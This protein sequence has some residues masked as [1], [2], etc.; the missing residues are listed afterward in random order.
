MFFTLICREH[1]VLRFSSE[2]QKWATGSYTY[3]WL[4]QPVTIY[5]TLCTSFLRY[6]VAFWIG[7]ISS[8]KQG[9]EVHGGAGHRTG[10]LHAKAVLQIAE[11]LVHLFPV[12]RGQ[13]AP[14]LSKVSSMYLFEARLLP[15]DMNF[16]IDSTEPVIF[17][18][19]LGSH[20]CNQA[21]LRFQMV[22]PL[23]LCSL[24]SGQSQ[25]Q[26]TKLW[27]SPTL[28]PLHQLPALSVHLFL[29]LACLLGYYGQD[30]HLLGS[31]QVLQHS[32]MY[33]Y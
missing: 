22:F 8:R 21:T 20:T 32:L 4:N 9:R 3:T 33:Y 26:G 17:P 30:V 2:N 11:C 24:V 15:M 10:H 29:L 31:Q 7:Q 6:N 16:H 19:R 1:T 25:G 27:E 23:C 28:R 13:V 18:T 14:H 5:L 12:W